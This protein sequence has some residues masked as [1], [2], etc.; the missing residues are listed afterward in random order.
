MGPNH[1]DSSSLP[2]PLPTQLVRKH[3]P[4]Y[5]K[6]SCRGI[7]GCRGRVCGALT[8]RKSSSP[9]PWLL[10]VSSL[11]SPPWF[12]ESREALLPPPN[13]TLYLAEDTAC[14]H[15]LSHMTSCKVVPSDSGHPPAQSSPIKAR[16]RLESLW[17]YGQ[18]TEFADRP[19]VVVEDG[20]EG[21]LQSFQREPVREKGGH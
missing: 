19:D 2:S 9:L 11:G 15:R 21:H 6:D 8:L 18:L 4:S 10:S 14:E 7:L 3:Y 5:D 1:S 12:P 13:P 17:V 16:R 20:G